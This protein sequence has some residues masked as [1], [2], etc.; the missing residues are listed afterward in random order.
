MVGDKHVFI[1][2][3]LLLLFEFSR[4][5]LSFEKEFIKYRFPTQ[6]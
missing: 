1:W 6:N 5:F 3:V 4:G 2:N